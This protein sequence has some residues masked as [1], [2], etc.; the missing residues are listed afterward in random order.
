MIKLKAML[1]DVA[2]KELF[3]EVAQ[4]TSSEETLNTPTFI[5]QPVPETEAKLF[6]SLVTIMPPSKF[7]DLTLQVLEHMYFISC[8]N[9]GL[10]TMEVKLIYSANCNC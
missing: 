7:P 1:K 2:L 9:I 3:A 6:H 4:K 8:T 5:E 10:E